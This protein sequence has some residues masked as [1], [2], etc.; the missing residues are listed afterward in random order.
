MVKAE[1]KLQS[2]AMYSQ[3]QM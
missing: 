3:L 1:N 2:V